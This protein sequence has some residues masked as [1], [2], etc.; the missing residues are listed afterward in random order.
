VFYREKVRQHHGRR[1]DH[2]LA[3]FTG[4]KE[5]ALNRQNAAFQRLAEAVEVPG[6]QRG[7]EG[8]MP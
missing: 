6:I 7:S 2:A 8:W 1:F 5:T 3:N 4:N